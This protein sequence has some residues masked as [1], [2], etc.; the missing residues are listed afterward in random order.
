MKKVTLILTIVLAMVTTANAG[1]VFVGWWGNW[2]SGDLPLFIANGRAII[3]SSQPAAELENIQILLYE[4]TNH[5]LVGDFERQPDG[6]WACLFTWGRPPAPNGYTP[7]LM[8][9]PNFMDTPANPSPPYQ[10]PQE[11]SA[12]F[13]FDGVEDW[14]EFFFVRDW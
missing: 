3:E 1:E 4:G 10:P 9:F 14:R 6:T 5:Y 13:N 12:I 7:M 8:G 2:E 11:G